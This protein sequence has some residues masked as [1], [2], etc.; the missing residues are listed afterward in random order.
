MAAAKPC[1]VSL[2]GVIAGL[3]PVTFFFQLGKAKRFF[4]LVDENGD[5]LRC[6]AH[7]KRAHSVALGNNMHVLLF[8]GTGRP[9]LGSSPA[10][11]Y[12]LQ[13]GIVYLLEKMP[14][15]GVRCSEI[16]KPIEV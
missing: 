9:L 12:I 4:F 5:S 10:A 8:A 13:D 16:C 15:C 14:F 11:V 7:G 1:R 2:L 3:E 6:C